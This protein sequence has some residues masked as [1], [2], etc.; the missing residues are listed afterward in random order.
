VAHLKRD[1]LS[2][3]RVEMWRRATRCCAHPRR[4]T[5]NAG[6]Y[7]PPA[8]R[9]FDESLLTESSVDFGQQWVFTGLAADAQV[10]AVRIR[11]PGTLQTLAYAS[12][13]IID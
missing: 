5:R 2:L 9:G 1:G 4:V 11:K 6:H 3:R 10:I 12:L 7:S 8:L 13:I